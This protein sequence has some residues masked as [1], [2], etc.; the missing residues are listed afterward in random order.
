MKRNKIMTN[1]R[2]RQMDIVTGFCIIYMIFTHI[3][4]TSY[5]IGWPIYKHS[6]NIFYAYLFFF[7][8]KSGYFNRPISDQVAC[9]KKNAKG[10][11]KPYIKYSFISYVVYILVK[12]ICLIGVSNLL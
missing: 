7:I 2:N 1:K 8:L 12:D 11:L 5:N 9:I 10:L 6:L 3:C 4:Q